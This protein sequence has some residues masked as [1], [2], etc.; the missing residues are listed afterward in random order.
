MITNC[1]YCIGNSLLENNSIA[2]TLEDSHI[3]YLSKRITSEQKL[4]DLGVIVL[5]LPDFNIKSALCD[6]KD[7]IQSAAYDVLSTWLEKQYDR[8]TAFTTL[9][10][11]LLKCDAFR[12]VAAELEQWVMGTEQKSHVSQESKYKLHKTGKLHSNTKK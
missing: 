11:A 12:S 5:N 9:H 6:H 4:M 7:S 2:G 3:L 8:Q 1:S 10:A